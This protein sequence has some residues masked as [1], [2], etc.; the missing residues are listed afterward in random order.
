MTYGKYILI[1]IAISICS[2]SAGEYFG[3]IAGMEREKASWEKKDRD[4]ILRE[5]LALVE[6][7][8]QN[9]AE[10]A[11]KAG[12]IKQERLNRE[13]MYGALKTKYDKVIADGRTSIIGGLRVPKSICEGFAAG[14]EG[15]STGGDVEK[16]TTRLPRDVEERLYRFAEDRDK[17]IIDFESFKNEVR[18][19]KCFAE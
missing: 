11:I 8:A 13:E 7:D 3:G 2:Y 16:T 19:S 5:S 17:I 12:K 14:V 10:E 1:I 9:K 15:A 6:K 4:R 18:I